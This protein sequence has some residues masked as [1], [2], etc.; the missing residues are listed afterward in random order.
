MPEKSPSATNPRRVIQLLRD[1]RAFAVLGVATLLF[2]FLATLNL[3]WPGSVPAEE[4]ASD[5]G[6]DIVADIPYESQS[7]EGANGSALDPELFNSSLDDYRS[8]LEN[9]NLSP[10]EIAQRMAEIQAALAQRAEALNRQRQALSDLADALS[11]SS[12]SAE[13]GWDC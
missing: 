1:V 4:L 8:D 6:A 13:A 7:Y 12:A 5:P 10:E 2:T 3:T 9:Q 11:D